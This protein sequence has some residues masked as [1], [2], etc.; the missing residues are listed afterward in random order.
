MARCAA[1]PKTCES[2]ND[3]TACTTVAAPATSASVISSSPRCLTMT[4]SIKYFELAGRTSPTRRLTSISAIPSASR[5]RCAQM[6]SLASRQA[7]ESEIFFFF[8]SAIKVSARPS[9]LRDEPSYLAPRDELDVVLF[10]QPPEGFAG[11]E[12]VVALAPSGAPVRVVERHGAHLLVVVGE[13]DD[14]LRDARLQ[15][16]Y[17]LG[18]VRGPAFGRD[19]GVD[20]YQT[21]DDD[22]VG[23]ERRG[24]EG[25]LREPLARD[26]RGQAVLARHAQEHLEER[27]RRVERAHVRVEVRGPYAEGAGALYLR[28]YLGLGLTHVQRA[29]GLALG[30]V[31]VSVG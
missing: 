27:A 16:L 21:V 1:T 4:S 2:V 12:V 5:E 23:A 28:A 29:G 14:E 31:E 9:G 10:Q 30:R 24:E 25:R 11:D 17:Q 19:R 13:V 18:V 26:E 22:A 7:C 20:V 15:A 6:S 3:V 8:S